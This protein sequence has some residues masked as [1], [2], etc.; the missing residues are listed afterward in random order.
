MLDNKEVGFEFINLVVFWGE[1]GFLVKDLFVVGYSDVS[2]S[3][4]V[5]I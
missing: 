2:G 3:F 5:C 1:N 4:L